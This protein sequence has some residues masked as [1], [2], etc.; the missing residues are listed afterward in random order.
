MLSPVASINSL[1][2]AVAI[3][4]LGTG[5]LGTLLGLRVAMEGFSTLVSGIILSGFFFGYVIGTYLIPRMILYAGFIRTFSALAAI[6]SAAVILH[7]LLVE[8]VTWW[9][10]RTITGICMVGMYMVIESWLNEQ[11]H[12]ARRGRVF[13]VYMTVNLLALAASQYLILVYSPESLASFALVAIFISLALVPV[14]L[15]PL[16]A[17]VP[18]RLTEFS[19]GKLFT[20]S[21][22]GASAALAS[23]FGNGAFWALGPVFGQYVGMTP[24][25]IAIF[26]SVVIFAGALSQW[27]IGYLSDSWD[28][29]KVL[30]LASFAGGGA[31]VLAYYFSMVSV[32][33][34]IG[35]AAIYGIF[36]FSVYSLAVA[37]TNDHLDRT[38]TLATTRGLLLLN[39]IGATVGPIIAGL[40]MSFFG[41]RSFLL[42][43]GVILVFL[44]FYAVYRIM[45]SSPIAAEEKM[46]FMPMARTSLVAAELD[47]RT[48]QEESR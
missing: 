40:L 27:P 42:Y 44:G 48:D 26:M 2:L 32:P 37:H 1:L 7:G 28:R 14:A 25:N 41:A 46:E 16:T 20:V 6:A 22:L 33:G 47:P 17:P 15:T 19:L 11:S 13:A 29:R 10:L 23:G 38:E 45:V 4:L 21:P 9:L 34:L 8:P 3:L 35:L 12:H 43:L 31:G 30:M 18:T 36:S 39:G 5:Y 24:G